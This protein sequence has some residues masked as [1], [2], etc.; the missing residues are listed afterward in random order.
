MG[1]AR[2]KKLAI[3]TS[4]PVQYYAPWFQYLAQESGLFIRVFYLWD[5]GVTRQVDAGFQQLVQW[6]VP[7]LSGYDYEFVANTSEDPGTKHFR[8]LRN[9]QLTERV[10]AFNPDA[11]LM[12]G[13]NYESL[14]RFLWN[15][16]REKAP[17][18][19]R[20]DSHRLI[21]RRGIKEWLRRQFLTTI[22]RRF[23]ACLYVG[24]ANSR[25]FRHHGVPDD[26]LFFA[27]HSVNNDWFIAQQQLANKQADR[28]KQELG[29]PATHHVVL[30]A[31]K[32]EEKKK[33]IDLLQAFINA[34]LERVILLFVG[35]G[36]LEAEM[37]KQAGQRKDILF[38][39]FQ[40]QSRMP[41]VFTVGDIFVLPSISETWGLVINEAM[42]MSRPAIVSS[43]V[44]C[45]EDLVR[46]GKNGLIFPAG[47]IDALTQCLK[48]AFSDPVRLHD[49]GRESQ[50]IVQDYSYAQA[51]KGLKQALAKLVAFQDD[52]NEHNFDAQSD[53]GLVVTR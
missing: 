11:V 4:H 10:K 40:N 43:H 30:F 41:M 35:A 32:F 51:T 52:G 48:D 2:P 13:Y 28:W 49:W 47:D 7:L 19:F 17:L 9:P 38:A 25:Y 22:F 1:A 24:K 12:I 14:Y 29:I 26:N 21:A 45:A 20:G 50:K 33:P 27:P 31:G 3:I 6:D 53:P 34:K 16:R 18:I 44:G 8:G 46:H 23:S 37:R 39:P 42:C 36:P 5:F 15:W